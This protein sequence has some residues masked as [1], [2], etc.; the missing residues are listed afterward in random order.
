VARIGL[1]FGMEVAAW[2]PNLTRKRT[3]EFGVE[4]APSLDALAASSDV[5]SVHLV[6]GDRTRGILGRDQIARMR[7]T[8]FLVN[9][10]RS[11]IV[12]GSALVDALVEGRIAGAG[13]D[14]FDRE[15]LPADHVLRTLP[16]ALA[17]PHLGYVAKDNYRTY[18]REAAEDIAAFDA[19]VPTRVLG[20]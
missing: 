9:T 17:T 1:A 11:S 3:D 4:L 2:S 7:R 20:P 12:D 19:G 13:L 5:L 10:A 6:L 14:V 16:T 15:P 18:F 8:A